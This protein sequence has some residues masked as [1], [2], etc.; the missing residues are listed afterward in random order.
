MYLNIY[1]TYFFA[2]IITGIKRFGIKQKTEQK[3]DVLT[4]Q[5]T[6]ESKGTKKSKDN[7]TTKSN[8]K[9]K[10]VNEKSFLCFE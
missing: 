2:L 9:T 3:T 8:H 4:D 6:G 10:N 1:F 5:N 7:N